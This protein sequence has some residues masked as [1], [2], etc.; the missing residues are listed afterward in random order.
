MLS[1]RGQPCTR[2]SWHVTGRR[3]HCGPAWHI[4]RPLL[5][6]R[7]SP[8]A[9][10]ASPSRL[11]PTSGADGPHRGWVSI[12]WWVP[13]RPEPTVG[14]WRACGR[15]RRSLSLQGRSGRG[16]GAGPYLAGPCRWGPRPGLPRCPPGAGTCTWGCRAV[17][18]SREA[19]DSGLPGAPGNFQKASAEAWEAPPGPPHPRTPD[20][21]PCGK[22][23]R[24]GGA[25]VNAGTLG[26]VRARCA[27]R[28]GRAQGHRVQP[29]SGA[30]TLL[31]LH[32]FLEI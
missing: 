31:H 22:R 17:E 15:C 32:I 12:S 3:G 24:G 9:G 7:A 25:G 6:A 8:G 18:G 2:D 20:P 21:A 27:D 19:S 11:P 28:A 4:P 29:R 10:G 13:S 16:D 1:P 30:L 23:L 26:R 5:G 14:Q